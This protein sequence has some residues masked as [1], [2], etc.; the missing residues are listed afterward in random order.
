MENI[1]ESYANISILFFSCYHS[2]AFHEQVLH[3]VNN[4][5]C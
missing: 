1:V 3:F 4:Q 2:F 5:I